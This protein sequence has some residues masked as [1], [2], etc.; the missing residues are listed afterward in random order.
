MEEFAWMWKLSSNRSILRSEKVTKN[1]FAALLDLQRF[2]VLPCLTLHCCTAV[3]LY[4]CIT[5]LLYYCTEVLLYCCTAA[6]HFA[7]LCWKGF[8]H[9]NCEKIVVRSKLTAWSVQRRVGRKIG[10]GRVA[11]ILSYNEKHRWFL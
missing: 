2:Y 6:H 10:R 9:H 5:V 1:K 11:L 7:A 3:L 8:L 4:W